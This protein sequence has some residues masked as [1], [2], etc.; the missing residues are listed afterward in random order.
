M[1]R[2]LTVIVTGLCVAP[3]CFWAGMAVAVWIRPQGGNSD[4]T[5]ANAIWAVLIG[6][7]CAAAGSLITALLAYQLTPASGLRYVLIADAIAVVATILV[8]NSLTAKTPE[9]RVPEGQYAVLDIEVRAEDSILGGR[10]IGEVVTNDFDGDG[11]ITTFEKL[12]R[13]EGE[14]AI[15][16]SEIQPLR[17][18][19]KEWAITVFLRDHPQE[20]VWFS[21]GL[22]PQ[23][24][25][26]V[27]WSAWISPAARAGHITPAGLMLRYRFRHARHGAVDERSL[28]Q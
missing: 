27:D 3:A 14:F 11:S 10:P 25:Q 22:P 6:I 16:P 9:L 13:R 20:S 19:T 24:Q 17:T 26:E 12:A 21:L 1:S 18:R 23:P 15:L 2:L 8:W 4:K 5:I 7:V 28:S